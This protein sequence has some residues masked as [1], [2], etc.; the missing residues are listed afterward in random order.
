MQICVDLLVASIG[1]PQGL[2]VLFLSFGSRSS[3]NTPMAMRMNLL[4]LL[5]ELFAF[6]RLICSIDVFVLIS[7]MSLTRSADSYH[8]NN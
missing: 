5:L 8:N 1:S 2:T 6:F 4:N 3:N 7:Q